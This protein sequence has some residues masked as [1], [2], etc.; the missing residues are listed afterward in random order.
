MEVSQ[1]GEWYHPGSMRRPANVD[2][3]ACLGRHMAAVHRCKRDSNAQ[4]WRHR[5]TR[6]MPD[7][8]STGKDAMAGPWDSPVVHPDTNEPPIIVPCSLRLERLAADERSTPFHDPGAVHLERRLMPVEVLS[9]EKIALLQ[10]E[11]V[12]RSQAD[13]LDPEVRPGLQKRFPDPCSLPR[14]GEDP[15]SRYP[16]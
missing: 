8:D 7:V 9:G 14:C 4:T 5:A 10:A 1:E 16:C 11:R 3:E 2:L 13:R 12:P 15:E 6:H